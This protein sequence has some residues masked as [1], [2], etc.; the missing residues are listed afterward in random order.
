[1]EEAENA[2][3]AILCHTSGLV[4]SG[5]CMVTA[6]SRCFKGHAGI[7]NSATAVLTSNFP[8]NPPQFL[9]GLCLEIPQF[10]SLRVCFC[11]FYCTNC[12]CRMILTA[13][14]RG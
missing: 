7:G 6:D 12:H 1:M 13:L 10:V 14:T 5:S 11:A 2:G 4:G 8:L 9:V 3:V